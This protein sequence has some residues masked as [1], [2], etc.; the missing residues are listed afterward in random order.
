MLT[1]RQGTTETSEVLRSTACCKEYVK[2]AKMSD[3]QI[4]Y[5]KEFI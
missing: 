2:K 4:S 5:D 3:N 1:A